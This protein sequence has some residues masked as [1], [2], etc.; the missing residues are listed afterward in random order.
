MFAAKKMC[1]TRSCLVK[2]SQISGYQ[3]EIFDRIEEVE[4]R[5]SVVSSSH[6]I[7]YGVDFLRCIEEYPPS[8]ITPYY[9][10]VSR[11]NEAVGIIYMQHVYVQL[12]KHLRKPGGHH[13]G[14]VGQ[15]VSTVKHEVVNAVNFHTIV[16][17]NLMLTGR[18]GYYFKQPIPIDVQAE[19]VS[20]ALTSLQEVLK[21]KGIPAG[22]IL[23]KDFFEQDIPVQGEKPMGFTK[24]SVQPKMILPIKD[25]WKDFNDYLEDVKSKY[26]IRARKAFSLASG[27]E[28]RTLEAE[29]IAANRAQ[30]NRLYRYVS[31]QAA[32]NAFTLHEAY[33]E[34]LKEALGNQMTFT[35]YWQEGK[36]VAFFTSIRNFDVLDA[37]FLGYEPQAN[38]NLH[39]Y[40]NM[41][42]DLI[43]EGISM[44]ARMVDLS[45]TAIEIKSTVGAVPH[46]MYLFLKHH[47]PVLNHLVK[48]V[49]GFV[50]PNEDFIIRNPFRDELIKTI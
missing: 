32:F 46:P 1:G 34:R 2:T 16:C 25:S 21:A 48:Q 47:S 9:G 17:G 14:F 24:F 39:L 44:R 28:K 42:Y 38:S 45:R 13:T 29:E 35:S 10:L 23:I 12:A 41:L 5:W 49:I 31:D 4:E 30:I 3:I 18:Y 37:H 20:S 36:M 22:M 27:I 15:I 33:F 7:F 50:K 26:R 6:D 8:G 43:R 19:L 11:Q 40:L